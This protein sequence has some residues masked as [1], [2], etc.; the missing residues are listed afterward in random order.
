MAVIGGFSALFSFILGTYQIY[1]GN[2]K[3]WDKIYCK[4]MQTLKDFST[5]NFDK[6]L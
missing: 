2:W 3:F 6:D 4:Q 5:N 1:N